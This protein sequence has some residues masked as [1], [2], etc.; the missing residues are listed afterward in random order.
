MFKP[1]VFLR[2][3]LGLVALVLIPK[4]GKAHIH[5]GIRLSTL[6]GDIQLHLLAPDASHWYEPAFEVVDP[7]PL[8]GLLNNES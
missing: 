8:I 5:L 7:P 4:K 6:V 1:G 2:E 3:L